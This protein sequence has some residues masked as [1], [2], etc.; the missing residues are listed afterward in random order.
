[1]NHH[2]A[3][4]AIGATKNTLHSNASIE[5][6]DIPNQS[7]QKFYDMRDT[8]PFDNLLAGFRYA[9]FIVYLDKPKKNA[10]LFDAAHDLLAALEKTLMAISGYT[11]QNEITIDACKSA[12]SAIAKARGEQ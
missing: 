7:E 4:R 3:L 8:I 2:A 10:A 12:R 1:M 5:Y 11:H 9:G 6:W